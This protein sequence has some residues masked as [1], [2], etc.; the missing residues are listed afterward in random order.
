MLGWYVF[1][2]L[3]GL[4]A[5]EGHKGMVRP[6]I[7]VCIYGAELDFATKYGVGKASLPPRW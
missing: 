6:Y 1:R 4:E 2:S 5:R 7:S 3:G